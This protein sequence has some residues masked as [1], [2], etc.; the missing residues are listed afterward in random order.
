M[1]GA[2]AVHATGRILTVVGAEDAVEVGGVLLKCVGAVEELLGDHGEELSLALRAIGVEESFVALLG[3]PAQP[4]EFAGANGHPFSELLAV[5]KG[6]GAVGGS[7]KHV[8]FVGKFVIDDVMTLFG[9]A[10]P[11]EDGVPHKDHRTPAKAWPRMGTGASTSP[12]MRSKTPGLRA[13]GTTVE[14]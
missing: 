3:E 13:G 10:R 1:H 6:R 5:S 11:V 2:G 7:V 4:Q 9:V 8:E 14:G 12:S